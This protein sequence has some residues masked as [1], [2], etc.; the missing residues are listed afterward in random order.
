VERLLCEHGIACPELFGLH[1]PGPVCIRFV[2]YEIVKKE[3]RIHYLYCRSAFAIRTTVDWISVPC[4]LERDI[5]DL[6]NEGSHDNSSSTKFK[7]KT[8][9]HEIAMAARIYLPSLGHNNEEHS[10]SIGTLITTLLPTPQ[11]EMCG[12]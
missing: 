1:I 11:R 7:F 9:R 12:D 10:H 2:E 8:R 3:E 6:H 5:E 4:S